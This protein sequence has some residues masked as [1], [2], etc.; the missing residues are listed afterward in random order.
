MIKLS[1]L[2]WVIAG[3]LLLAT[4]INYV[5]RLTLSVVLSEVRKTFT[6]SEAGY[7]HIVVLFMI[8]YAVAYAVS[9]YV[10]DRLGTRRGMGVFIGAW[11]AAQMLQALAWGK[12]SL[13]ACQFSL[14]LCEAGNF[15]AG[16][17]AIG[18]WFPPEL[19][20]LGVGLVN[21]GSALGLALAPPL[22]AFV[23]L[24]YGWRA[25]F[26]FTGSL[27]V[28]LLLAWLSLYQTPQQ[29]RWLA[30]GERRSLVASTA[31]PA[32]QAPARKAGG[33][34]WTILRRPECYTL[35]LARFFSDPVIY[36]LEFWVPSYLHK[37]RGF[38]L[39]MIG[40]YAWV[41][42]VFGYVGY[43]GGGWL[44]GRLLRAGMT[45][46]KARKSAMAVG[47]LLVPAA[48]LVPLAPNAALALAA[49]CLVVFG[50]AVWVTNL[51]T[52]P[53]DLFPGTEVGT[54][55]GF[56]GMGGAL[57]GIITSLGIGF[58]LS[59]FSYTPLF[60]CAGLMHPLSLLLVWWLLPER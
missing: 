35:V 53:A 38:D 48:M 17:K 52:L 31:P 32:E 26:L 10:V 21:S 14:G 40:K 33:S 29:N 5:D 12:W 4:I 18:E 42:F 25:A 2:R 23:T 49:L 30:E 54:A 28:I 43:M 20:A 13:G 44:S 45:L 1:K 11:S 19:R 34:A 37:A 7:S 41:P 9:G 58:V 6:L 50:H 8:A 3:L 22:A 16:V 56:T 36:F 24:R 46:A 15:P 27:G 60:L 47:A 51:L 39:A 55:S 57:G 59:H